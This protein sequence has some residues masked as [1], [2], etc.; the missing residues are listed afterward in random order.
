CCGRP[1]ISK[2]Q[3]ETAQ[4]WAKANIRQLAPYAARGVPIVGTEPSC[5]LTLRDEYPELLDGDEVKAVA[6]QALLVDELIARTA[7]EDPSI[8]ALFQPSTA[9]ALLHG[10]CHQKATA[11]MESTLAVLGLVPGLDAELIDSAC[12]GMAGSFGFEAEHYDISRAMAERTLLPA[13]ES[14]SDD[15]AILV[16]GVS[17]R[18]QIGHFSGRRPQHVIEL[19][20]AS[21]RRS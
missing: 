13:V 15:T 10:H 12:C 19:L 20:A 17:C 2:G 3:L 9:K 18:Q 5:I 1:L 14:A 21:L 8:A 7:V 4:A 16:T 11:G 6:G